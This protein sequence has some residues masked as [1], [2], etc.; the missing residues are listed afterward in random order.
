MKSTKGSKT[1]TIGELSLNIKSTDTA[2]ITL[3]SVY[4]SEFE[5]EVKY[6]YLPGHPGNLSGR[7]EDAEEPMPAELTITAVVLTAAVTFEGDDCELRVKRGADLMGMFTGAQV[8][9]L[10][11]RVLDMIE[12]GRDE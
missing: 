6:D 11:D 4:A 10:E 3:E 12:G 8:S 7:F 2:A 1:L 9:A 5:V